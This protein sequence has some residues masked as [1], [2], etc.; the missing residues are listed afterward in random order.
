M[1]THFKPTDSHSSPVEKHTP[2]C[3][4]ASK[5]MALVNDENVLAP[6]RSVMARVIKAQADVPD[7]HVLVRDHGTEHDVAYDDDAVLD[8]AEG[9]VFFTVPRCEYQPR[10]GCAGPAKRAFFIDDH[11]EVTLRADQT[12]RTLR[13]LFGLTV[14]VRL[15]RDFESPQ[16]EVIGPDAAVRFGDG[17]VFYTR[18]AGIGLTITVNKQTF[19]E[20]DGVKREMS[21]REIASLITDQPAEVHRLKG[22]NEIAVALD[23]QVKLEGCEEFEVIRTNVAGG[24]EPSRVEREVALLR[25]NGAKLTFVEGPAPAVIYRGVRTRAGYPHLAET[26]VLVPVP[27]AYPGALLDGAYLP[28]GS[29]LLGRVE[30]SPQGTTL[31]ADGRTWQLVSYH[32]HNGGGGPAWNPSR[33]GFHTYYTEVL[34]W[35]QRARV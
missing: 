8:L 13:E 9:N 35:I 33:H 11:P 19:G 1:D 17:P 16:D 32:P 30:G 2:N 7:D 22:G 31:Q 20:A 26:D 14:T 4:P 27:P 24:F 3:Q 15:F 29:P 10:C 25:E 6:T 12:G 34:S 21:G 5:W 28:Q 18:R 23:E